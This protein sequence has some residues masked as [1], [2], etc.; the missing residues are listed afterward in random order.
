M[1][2]RSQIL[3]ALVLGAMSVQA[4]AQQ[5]FAFDLDVP[6]GHSSFWGV[7]DLQG[8]QSLVAEVEVREFRQHSRWAANFNIALRSGSQR[9]AFTFQRIERKNTL[10]A[11]VSTSD[12][13]QQTGELDI[14][15]AVIERRQ[16]ATL[17]LDWSEPGVVAV[18][19][20]GRPVGRYRLEFLPTA[21]RV[22]ASTIELSGHSLILGSGIGS[23]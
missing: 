14:D 8:A 2:R 20:D 21:V 5:R 9:W 1:S 10:M 18:S 7:D 3:I 6:A 22:G 23:R 17:A 15:G 12:G 13:G 11:R 4:F 19:L 16:R